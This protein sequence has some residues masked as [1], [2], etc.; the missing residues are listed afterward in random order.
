MGLEDL[1]D[2]QEILQGET[3]V[4]NNDTLAKI[5]AQTLN[6]TEQIRKCFFGGEENMNPLVQMH[7]YHQ[8][9]GFSNF[10]VAIGFCRRKLLFDAVEELSQVSADL[11]ILKETIEKKESINKPISIQETTRVNQLS[12]RSFE[13]KRY[14]NNMENIIK[15][16]LDNDQTNETSNQILTKHDLFEKMMKKRNEK[17]RNTV[18]AY[19]VPTFDV[20]RFLTEDKAKEAIDHEKKIQ[21]LNYGIVEDT[22]DEENI[23]KANH[24]N[25]NEQSPN[26]T[27]SVKNNTDTSAEEWNAYNIRDIEDDNEI[28]TPLDDWY[29]ESGLSLKRLGESPDEHNINMTGFYM[30]RH[31]H[32][33]TYKYTLEY[34]LY[35]TSLLTSLH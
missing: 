15:Q 9:S 24:S 35:F 18:D 13:L 28:D 10:N 32:N 6:R 14:I 12:R 3:K 31:L 25:T 5:P 11:I 22:D 30:K 4:K 27:Q 7:Q 20:I 17:K 33:S 21:F 23:I 19:G 2:F 26:P 29:E 1:S 16:Y 34:Y 8:K